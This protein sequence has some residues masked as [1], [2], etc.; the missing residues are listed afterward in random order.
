MKKLLTLSIL[1]LIICK[2]AVAQ[3]DAWQLIKTA[4]S[5]DGRSECGLA[6]VGG[7]LYLVGGDGPIKPVQVFD[8]AT[9]NWVAKAAPPIEMH[10]FQAASS[11]S[12]VYVL[13]AF[14]QGGYPNQIPA[15]NAYSYD[16]QKDTWLKLAGLP[17]NRQRAGA[18]AAAYNG[19]LY[20]V[21]GITH[22]HSSGT[23]A[24]FD[25]YDPKTDSWTALPNAP[26]MRDH[27]QAVVIGDK[28]YALGGR[29]TSL[30]D[31]DNFMSFF[32]KVVLEVVVFDFKAGTW[33]TLPFNLPAGTGGT[34]VGVN[35][36]LLF[37]GGERAT[38]TKSNAPQKD[39]FMLDTKTAAGWV[40]VAGL[41]MAR[42]GVG[43]TAI[44]NTIYIAGG[45][46]GGPGGPPPGMR[47]GSPNMPPNTPPPPG[48]GMPSNNAGIALEAY[49]LQ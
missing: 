29:N 28:F 16:T 38:S 8:P 5:I 20:L 36:K 42:N 24:M 18:G 19:K 11:G 3:P 31:P 34:A 46:G 21:D 49:R 41:N 6:A 15:P 44:G 45:A 40:K 33:S 32:D 2:M 17:A 14:Y 22:G 27:S 39:V 1:L 37:I 23:N 48:G 4:N 10:H 25:C 7:K 30:H 12:K 9:N 13:D 35:G 26:H 43:G 47:P